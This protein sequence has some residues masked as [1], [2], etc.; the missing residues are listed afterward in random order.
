MISFVWRCSLNVYFNTCCNACAYNKGRMYCR[1]KKGSLNRQFICFFRHSNSWMLSSSFI[2]TET[3]LLWCIF[4]LADYEMKK[5]NQ[6]RI[7]KM[8]TKWLGWFV[9]LQV[10]ID[11]KLPYRTNIQNY[12]SNE[13]FRS[14]IE[15]TKKHLI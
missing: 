4:D 11:P 5:S 10:F 13:K 8:L 1:Q 6:I 7:L 15:C 12:S 3:V 2:S 14:T 9:L